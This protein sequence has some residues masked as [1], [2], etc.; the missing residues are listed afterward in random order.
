MAALILSTKLYIP[1]LR[2]NLT[3]RPRLIERLN[4]GLRHT[5]G[6]TLISAPAGFGKTTLVNE[7]LRQS[8]I[9]AAWLSLDETDND[10][11]RF[12]TY[13]VAALQQIVHAIGQ[14]GQGT[15]QTPHS[16]PTEALLTVLINEIAATSTPFV[17]VLDDYHVIKAQSIHHALTF[18]LEHLPPHPGPGGQCQGMHV[19]ITCRADPPLPLARWRGRGQLTELSHSDKQTLSPRGGLL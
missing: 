14:I 4:R 6:V 15:V 16:A 10:P 2:P 1:P 9:C 5:P 18:L 12:L 19:V 3:P 11:A 17:L 8:D 7:W 13:L